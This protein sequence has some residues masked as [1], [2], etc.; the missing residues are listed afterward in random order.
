[1]DKKSI[2][3][4][5]M[6][7]KKAKAKVRKFTGLSAQYV[8]YL[9]RRMKAMSTSSSILELNRMAAAA[10]LFGITDKDKILEFVEAADRVNVALSQF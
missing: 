5:A 7:L 3:H 6:A 4:S 8:D 1:M 9:N 2:E 10:G